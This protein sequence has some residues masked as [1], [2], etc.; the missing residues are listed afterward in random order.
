M[1]KHVK[2]NVGGSDELFWVI[3]GVCENSW[4]QSP[5]YPITTLKHDA[6][7]IRFKELVIKKDRPLRM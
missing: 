1:S 4:I 7:L 5:A 2:G 3:G 6:M